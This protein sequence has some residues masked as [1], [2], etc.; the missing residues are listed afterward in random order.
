MLYYVLIGLSLALAGAVGL[1]LAY[2]FY[3]DRLDKERKKRVAEL[4]RRCIR[5][6]NRLEDAE[7]RISEQEQLI[8]A[9]YTDDDETWAEVLDDR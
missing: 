4:E 5:L 8:A 1:Q 6:Q 3:F 9:L 2:M 7:R